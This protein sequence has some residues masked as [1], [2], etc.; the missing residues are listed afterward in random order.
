M[1]LMRPAEA[2]A[3]L[4]VSDRT[5]RRIAAAPQHPAGIPDFEALRR[6]S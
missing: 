5:L 4:R 6:K 1:Q 3:F 2:A